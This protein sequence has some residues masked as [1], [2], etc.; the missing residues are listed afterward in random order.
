MH[1]MWNDKP[2]LE[3]LPKRASHCDN[4]YQKV[5]DEQTK[6]Q[7]KLRSTKRVAVVAEQSQGESSRSVN[8][9]DSPQTWDLYDGKAV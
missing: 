7:S 6:G 3:T 5:R 8:R 9:K 1:T 4:R 2:L